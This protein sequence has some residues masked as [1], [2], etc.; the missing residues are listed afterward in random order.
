MKHR[1][2]VSL[3]SAA[4]IAFAMG[5]TAPAKPANAHIFLGME[6]GHHHYHCHKKW[7]R[8][9]VWSKKYHKRIW[10]WQLRRVCW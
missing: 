7:V 5:M 2:I 3:A 6:F 4:A 9:K 1:A 10:V 8:V